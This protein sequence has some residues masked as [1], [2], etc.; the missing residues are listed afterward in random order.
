MRFYG[1]ESEGEISIDYAGLNHFFWANRVRVRGI[2]VVQDLLRKV[3]KRGFTT[4]VREAYTDAMGHSS[5]RELATALFDETG[6]MPYLGDRHTCEFFPFYVT[7]K[8]AMK[9]YRLVRT[10]I[11][12]RWEGFRQRDKRLKALVSGEIPE[13]FLRRS[14][15]SAADIVS[16]HLTG[17]AFIDVG[18]V[19]NIGQIS[20]VLRG[21]VV[22]TAVRVD[23]NGFAPI[24]FGELPQPVLSFVE[25]TA[26]VFETTVR[27]CLERDRELAL[28]ALRMDPVCSRL[29]G[30]RVRELG[31]RLIGAHKAFV[32]FPATPSA[33]ATREGS[34]PC[35]GPGGPEPHP[36]IGLSRR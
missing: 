22:E 31:T 26:H 7:D 9:R 24:C 25:Q 20:N 30:E 35:A 17:K 29:T 16:A 33:R 28:R 1:L 2:D 32:E 13:D 34:G 12:E 8:A 11:E 18:N 10:S 21:A 15:E 27:A 6:V 4:L 3:R 23:G 19:P 14:R 36:R 5:N